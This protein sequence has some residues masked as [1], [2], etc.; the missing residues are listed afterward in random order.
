MFYSFDSLRKGCRCAV[1]MALLCLVAGC[2]YSQYE[3]RLN[4]SKNYYAHLDRI[5]QALASKWT[6]Q[7][8]VLELRVPRQFVLI[9]PPQPIKKDD[10]NLEFPA[11]D[12][13]QPDYVNLLFPELFGAW[14]TTVK[15]LQKDG[16]AEERKGYIYALS[17]YWE[18]A[19]DKPD[20]AAEFFTNLKALMSDKLGVA[21]TDEPPY[22][23][24]KTLP[25]Y[26]QQV[27]Y[28]KCIFKEKDIE[29]VSYSF[30][31]YA[32]RAGSVMGV[33]VIVLPDSMDAPQ[34]INERI[35]YMLGSLTVTSVPPKAGADKNAA[36]QQAGPAIQF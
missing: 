28:D 26:Q 35:P 7:G 8:G 34:K 29:G 21:A 2:G 18:L 3:A 15:V 36:P 22:V 24:P 23:Y 20:Q 5:E 10:G 11:I 1:P 25:A 14:E 16:S 4:E 6:S 31:V 13:R 12:P 17:N 30:E 9:P 19:G 27:T 32:R 33:I